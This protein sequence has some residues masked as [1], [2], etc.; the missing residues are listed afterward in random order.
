MSTS[1]TPELLLVLRQHR[2]AGGQRVEHQL[3]DFQAAAP[4]ALDDVLGRALRAGHDVHLGFQAYAAHADGLAHVLAVDHELLRLDQQQALVGRD[5]DGLGR[6]DHARHVGL[7]DFLVLHRHHAA[8]VDAADVAAGDAGVDTG[9]L[10]VGH[11]LGLFQGLLDALHRGVDVDHHAALEAVARRDAQARELE[12][13][14]R[15]D[16][17]HHGHDLAGADV[18]PDH[19][20]FVFLGH[21]FTFFSFRRLCQ[22]GFP[23]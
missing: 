16:L 11:Q 4:H 19:Q 14:A 13:A 10:A 7:R 17:G 8:G 21:I 9:D 18:Q 3:V 12:L 6:L 5:V 15:H 2:Q 23:W 22:R 20:I 1:A